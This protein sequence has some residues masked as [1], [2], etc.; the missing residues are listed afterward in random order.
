M[1]ADGL[2][3][4][5]TVSKQGQMK[6][7]WGEA[8]SQEVMVPFS[9]IS[10]VRMYGEHMRSGLGAIAM[11]LYNGNEIKLF[12]FVLKSKE[13]TGVFFLNIL[14]IS[15]TIRKVLLL[16]LVIFTMY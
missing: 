14:F 5:L 8:K 6:A 16:Q 13:C 3:A 10:F 11:N 1:C 12:L 15:H 9:G 4:S 7:I 2:L